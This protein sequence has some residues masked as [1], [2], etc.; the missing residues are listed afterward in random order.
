[1]FKRPRPPSTCILSCGNRCR[2]CWTCASGVSERAYSLRCALEDRR[3]R[4]FDRKKRARE[5]RERRARRAD[6]TNAA[7]FLRTFGSMAGMN[8]CPPNP[9]STVITSTMY[10]RS[11][12]GRIASTGVDGLMAR[13]GFIPLATMRSINALVALSDPVADQGWRQRQLCRNRR[14]QRCVCKKVFWLQPSSP[15]KNSTSLFL[16][17]KLLKNRVFPPAHLLLQCGMLAH[18]RR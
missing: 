13:A 7:N 16:H 4:V 17:A 3:Q 2:S 8:D 12:N 6:K 11:T 1:M 5:R 18:L 14:S 9:G 10:R 15:A